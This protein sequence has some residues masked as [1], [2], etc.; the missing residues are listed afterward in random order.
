MIEKRD[1]NNKVIKVSSLI[2]SN[3]SEKT[4]KIPIALRFDVCLLGKIDKI[5]AK[6][7]ISR[8]SMIS[9]WCSKGIERE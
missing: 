6:R 1:L 4:K 9:Y 8:N 2:D 5:A 3:E 7:G